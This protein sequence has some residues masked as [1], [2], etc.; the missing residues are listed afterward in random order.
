[1]KG[2]DFV[3]QV[4]SYLP[5]LRLLTVFFAEHEASQEDRGPGPRSGEA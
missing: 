2:M 4:R 1:M 5:L 3:F